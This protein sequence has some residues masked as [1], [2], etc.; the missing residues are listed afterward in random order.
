MATWP[1]LA[2]CVAHFVGSANPISAFSFLGLLF[3]VLISL[4]FSVQISRLTTR[5]K[6]LAQQIAILDSELRRLISASIGEGNPDQSAEE[7]K[8][9][10]QRTD[11]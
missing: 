11:D 2:V 7:G 9:S 6:D 4:Q 10:A 3:L 8:E 1:A 5:N